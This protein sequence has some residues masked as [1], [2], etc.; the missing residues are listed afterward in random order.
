MKIS[1]SC[2]AI[3][4]LGYLPPWTVNAGFVVGPNYTL[5]VDSGPNL[6]SAQTIHGYAL[7]VK[8]SNQ[9]VVINTEQHLDHVSG[10]FYFRERGITVYGHHQI[11]RQQTDLESDIQDYNACIPQELR[12]NL[13]EAKIFY[14]DTHLENPNYPIFEEFALDLGGVK[15]EILM[16]PGH[17][18]TNL[19]VYFPSESVLFCGDC[20]VTDYWPNYEGGGVREWQQWLSSLAKIKTLGPKLIVPGHGQVLEEPKLSA[21]I[22]RIQSILIKAIEIANH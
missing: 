7:N 5:V 17:T 6:V 9:L 8:P 4:G 21:E 20:I 1:A 12:R 19:S 3:T 11:K 18:P 16:T 2:Y 22:T 14:A 10:N 15:A 13:G